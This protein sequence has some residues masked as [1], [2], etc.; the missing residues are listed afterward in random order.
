M[1]PKKTGQGA[2][3]KALLNSKHRPL[4][5]R[6]RATAARAIFQMTELLVLASL[7]MCCVFVINT[8]SWF[9]FIAI[10]KTSN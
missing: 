5:T 1:V 9:A 7:P 8:I 6:L 10:M 4:K 2:Y 3:L